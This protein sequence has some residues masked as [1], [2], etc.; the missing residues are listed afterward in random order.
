MK[1][2]LL[3]G[4]FLMTVA[5]GGSRSADDEPSL[6]ELAEEP[7]APPAA[8]GTAAPTP[9]APNAP[10]TST[11]PSGNSGG[12]ANGPTPCLVAP[13][14]SDGVCNPEPGPCGSTDPDCKP[15]APA[16]YDCD[17][18]K[19][20]CQTFAPVVCPKGQVPSV[21]N[22]CYGECVDEALCAPVDDAVVCAA[23]IEEPDG[24]CSRPDDDPCRS[25]D[26]DCKL[27]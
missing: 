16:A 5:C 27:P 8:P 25:Q 13:P 17:Q 10:P 21:V 9:P 24:K 7:A 3:S 15:P 26:P 11:P 22:E 4:L 12:G 2:R 18:T 20:I 14:R 6:I 19:I 23:F 1:W